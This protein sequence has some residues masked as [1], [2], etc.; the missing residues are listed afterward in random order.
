MGGLVEKGCAKRFLVAS[1][2][3]GKENA[4]SAL[5]HHIVMFI[6]GEQGVVPGNGGLS[7]ATSTLATII[8][9]PAKE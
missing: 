3:G 8:S 5:Q 7:S 4:L 1:M 6:Y 2:E 9:I